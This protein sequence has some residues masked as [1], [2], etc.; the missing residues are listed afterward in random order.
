MSDHD[1]AEPGLIDLSRYHVA[2]LGT[3]TTCD[4][5]L[6]RALRRLLTPAADEDGP[7]HGFSNTI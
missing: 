5:G 7:H 3:E 6:G 2:D 4:S 1:P